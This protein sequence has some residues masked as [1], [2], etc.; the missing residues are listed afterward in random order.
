MLMGVRACVHVCACVC[1]RMHAYACVCMR[2][3]AYA[4]V[5][6]WTYVD[7][8]G[9]MRMHAYACMYALA[10]NVC[11]LWPPWMYMGTWA[12]HTRGDIDGH[13]GS[14]HVGLCQ[15]KEGTVY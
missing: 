4:C 8:C 14:A 9:R 7:V 1:M 5:C 11:I 15:E 2:M 10:K 3:H 12:P 6:M 13:M